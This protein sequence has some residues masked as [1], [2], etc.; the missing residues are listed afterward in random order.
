M[1]AR[2]DFVPLHEVPARTGL[3]YRA[4]RRRLAAGEI[5]VFRDPLDRRRR[6]VPL[7]EVEQLVDVAPITKKQSERSVELAAV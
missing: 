4:L 6:L 2:S 5:R 3:S 7:S 1:T